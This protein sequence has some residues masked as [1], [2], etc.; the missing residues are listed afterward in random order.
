MGNDR[1]HV[2]DL[3]AYSPAM[4]EVLQQ[5]E[6]VR[7]STVAV[8]MLGANGTGKEQVARTI[9]E[10]GSRQSEPFILVD[11]ADLPADVLDAVLF[12][13]RDEGRFEL[14]RGGTLFLRNIHTLPVGAQERLLRILETGLVERAGGKHIRPVKARLIAAT[15]QDLRPLVES[16][17]FRKDLFC[18]LN[19]FPIMLPPLSKRREDVAPLAQLFVERHGGERTPPVHAIEEAALTALKAYSWPGNV[20]ELELVVLGAILACGED[21]VVHVDNLPA[22]IRL[23]APRTPTVA[24]PPPRAETDD[25]TIVPLSELERRAIAHALRV[26]GGNVT[27]A[28]RALGIGRATMYRKLDRFK[29]TAARQP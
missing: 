13:D 15:H 2:A 6:L 14:A 25:D 11:C 23:N 10:T 18:R 20:R 22:N 1:V 27:R 4:R 21:R 12:G 9:H 8:L 17:A 29:L 16:G 7:E 28:A 3:V 24:P 26:T 5:V 19:V